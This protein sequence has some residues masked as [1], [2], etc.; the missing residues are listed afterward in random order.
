GAAPEKTPKRASEERERARY[1]LKMLERW[2]QLVAEL[3]WSIEQKRDRLSL[4]I[5]LPDGGPLRLFSPY[6]TATPGMKA[7]E[8]I[9]HAKQLGLPFQKDATVDSVTAAFLL[10]HPTRN[11]TGTPP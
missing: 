5:G 4:A 10:T 11:P 6:C 1:H 7:K 3:P 8:M 9:E 2:G